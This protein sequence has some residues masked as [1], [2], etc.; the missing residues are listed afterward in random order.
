VFFYYISI[1]QLSFWHKTRKIIFILAAIYVIAGILLYLFQDLLLFH[2]AP[3][4]KN[5]E[6]HFD[7]PFEEF[8]IPIQDRNL[9]LLKFHPSG[10]KKGIVLFFHGNMKNVEHYKKY[11]AYFL[12][13]SYEFWMADYPGFGKSTGERT[14]AN[15][16]Q[17]ALLIYEMALTE[18]SADSIIIYGK[19]I[20][21]GIAA[22]T[23]SQKPCRRLILE[24]PYYSI[25][26][27]AKSYVPIYP[28]IPM[29]NYSFPIYKYL[30]ATKATVTIFHGTE[31]EII[32]YSHA[33]RLIK[34]NPGIELISIKNGKHNNLSDFPLYH[35][36]LDSL[37][38]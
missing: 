7:Q 11:P 9:N 5:Y 17:D 19:S 4:D 32:P 37:L 29:T 28:V 24:T 35:N 25:D 20:G 2:P 30:E 38:Q 10:P 33:T 1:M 8:N 21:T 34:E 14:E 12:S 13:K 26:A 3:L 22:F 36:K 6:Y 27:L 23:A 31:D 18:S 16:N 15:M